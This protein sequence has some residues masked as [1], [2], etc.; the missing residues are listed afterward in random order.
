M[1]FMVI[2]TFRGGDPVPVYRRF[3]DRGR[4]MPDGIEYRASWVNDD[5]RRCFQIMECKDRRLLDEWIANWSDITEFQVIPVITSADAA[6]RVS[7]NL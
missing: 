6:A 7:S 3:R 2:E 1:L 5:L 4:L